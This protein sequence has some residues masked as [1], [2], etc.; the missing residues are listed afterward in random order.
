M[1]EKEEE[2]TKKGELVTEVD[3]KI[4]E[5]S[6]KEDKNTSHENPLLNIIAK[7][8]ELE[9]IGYK[10]RSFFFLDP[11]VIAIFG[12]KVSDQLT[13]YS[14]VGGIPNN[15]S[16]A[17][18]ELQHGQLAESIL[19]M[20]YRYHEWNKRSLRSNIFALEDQAFNYEGSIRDNL[21]PFKKFSSQDLV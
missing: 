3:K 4:E 17:E 2:E 18:I 6:V 14:F 11:M 5:K 12:E 13:F 19:F 9:K 7:K 10:K 15:S 20:G 1:N 16:K 21:D 8:K